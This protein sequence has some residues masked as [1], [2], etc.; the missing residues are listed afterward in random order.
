M[1][2]VVLLNARQQDMGDNPGASG[3]AQDA[4]VNC[5]DLEREIEND[6]A[7]YQEFMAMP[8]RK[9]RLQL[10]RLREW[11]QALE[12]HSQPLLPY[13]PYSSF[14]AKKTPPL[15]PTPHSHRI[16]YLQFR[17]SGFFRQRV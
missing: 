17:G 2:I 4:E 11:L 9:R 15:L 10:E 1:S 6:P 7:W 8:I 14:D 13:N 12:V 3:I 5:C 16:D